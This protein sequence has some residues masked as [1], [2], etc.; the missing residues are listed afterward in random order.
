MSSELFCSLETESQFRWFKENYWF[1]PQEGTFEIVRFQA[2]CRVPLTMWT[3]ALIL[4]CFLSLIVSRG[5][6]HS[7]AGFLPEL[8]EMVPSGHRGDKQPTS[9]SSLVSVCHFRGRLSLVLLVSKAPI[10]EPIT[11]ARKTESSDWSIILPISGVRA[12]AR[13]LGN[14]SR[15]R[16][17][18]VL[19]LMVRRA[20]LR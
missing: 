18:S 5:W 3:L 10:P 9:T 8:A 17:G 12:R 13:Y 20:F 1:R 19:G 16:T 4:L 15:L 14:C 11:V 7:E 2:Q 6:L